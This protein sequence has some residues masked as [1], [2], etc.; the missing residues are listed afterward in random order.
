MHLVQE[1]VDSKISE[2]PDF[3]E[4]IPEGLRA[5]VEMEWRLSL[6]ASYLKDLITEK[7]RNSEQNSHIFLENKAGN[8]F[9]DF[10]P[11][12]FPGQ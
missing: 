6:G 5:I 1:L 2:S 4:S 7:L 9:N 8:V 12:V 3:I 10:D 11:R